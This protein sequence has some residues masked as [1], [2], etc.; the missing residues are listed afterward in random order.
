MADEE[1]DE[2]PLS[3]DDLGDDDDEAEGGAEAEKEEKPEPKVDSKKEPEPEPIA[4]DAVAS[5]K[6]RAETAKERGTKPAAD[7][8]EY[9]VMSWQMRTL[10]EFRDL[11]DPSTEFSRVHAQKLE[12]LVRAGDKGPDIDYRAAL[13]ASSDP[14]ITRTKSQ[15]AS[16]S[17]RVAAS[18]RFERPSSQSDGERRRRDDGLDLTERE[19]AHATGKARIKDKAALRAVAEGLAEARRMQ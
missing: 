11:T 15:E 17:S 18:S 19:M 2:L 12:E 10:Q 14:R 16:R 5:Y 6:A 13:A 4:P 9:D 3:A 8:G 7:P 1:K